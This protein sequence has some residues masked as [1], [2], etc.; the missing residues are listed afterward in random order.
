MVLGTILGEVATGS[1]YG[2]LVVGN[3]HTGP[4]ERVV[5]F[6][7]VGIHSP[8][9]PEA[10]VRQRAG[11][12]VLREGKWSRSRVPRFGSVCPILGGNSCLG[13]LNM[14]RPMLTLIL[15]YIVNLKPPKP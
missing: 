14:L 10:P 5:C 6:G 4:L 15:P 12:K 3:Y 2:S 9:L 1:M 8:F 11:S 7:I 13:T